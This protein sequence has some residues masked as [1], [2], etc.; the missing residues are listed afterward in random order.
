[1]PKPIID[2]DQFVDIGLGKSL[3]YSSIDNRPERGDVLLP[4]IR[5]TGASFSTREEQD[6]WVIVD[7]SAAFRISR[8]RVFSDPVSLHS[9][10]PLHIEH[11]LNRDAWTTLAT[12]HAPFGG[13]ADHEP[14]EIQLPFPFKARYVRLSTPKRGR[15]FFDYVE[16]CAKIPASSFCMLRNV[17]V[18]DAAVTA[19][20]HHTQS[21]GFSW[22]FSLALA[23]IIG[24]NVRGVSIDK[25]SFRYCLRQ[26]KDHPHDDPYAEWF[27]GSVT[28][29]SVLPE[30]L[31]AVPHHGV[32]ANID[33]ASV[34]PFSTRYFTP[35]MKTRTAAQELC[36]RLRVD[37]ER[38]IAIVY[39]G[40]DKSTE[41]KPLPIEDYVAI[42]MSLRAAHPGFRV[43]IQTDQAEALNY[44]RSV[45]PD[46][47]SIDEIPVVT[48]STAVHNHEIETE[49]GITK[50]EF[51]LRLVAMMLL[52]SQVR[53]VITHTGNMGLWITLFRGGAADLFQAGSD[54]VW[55]DPEG[56][57]HVPERLVAA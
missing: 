28:E 40:T 45:V 9:M 10:L 19:E 7:L 13:R 14:L 47:I 54:G 5:P 35:S 36:S 15:L 20:Y 8:I 55:R 24:A 18:T 31:I 33:F 56:K 48:G 16:I 1:M 50:A 44:V 12:R 3:E 25:V 23:F 11:S 38:T 57:V 37:V 53:F 32:Y 30:G 2:T 6:P 29:P 43:L 21:Y 49:F 42:A 22:V 41:V 52:V 51:G 27:D 17:R 26:F 34:I 39:R 4:G 46:A